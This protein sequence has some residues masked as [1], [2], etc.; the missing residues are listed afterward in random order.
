MRAR[1][2]IAYAYA[3]TIIF[4]FI[5]FCT[6]VQEALPLHPGGDVIP[7][8]QQYHAEGRGFVCALRRK[9]YAS[10]VD[11]EDGR[12]YNTLNVHKRGVIC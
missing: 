8:P 6:Y 9:K 7:A 1:G 2:L 12:G 3:Q 11:N 10:C 4:P 5:A